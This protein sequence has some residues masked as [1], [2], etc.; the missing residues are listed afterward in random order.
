MSKTKSNSWNFSPEQRQEWFSAV[1]KG[2]EA[3]EGC[4]YSLTQDICMGI[5]LYILSFAGVQPE[6]EITYVCYKNCRVVRF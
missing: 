1:K 3:M 5:L 2:Q 6:I 4:I